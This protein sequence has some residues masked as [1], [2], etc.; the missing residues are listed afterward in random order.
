MEV[1]A[2][3]GRQPRGQSLADFTRSETA[4]LVQ[5]GDPS[6]HRGPLSGP[7]FR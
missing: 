2:E 3:G 4:D 1:D 5:T 6:G 7:F